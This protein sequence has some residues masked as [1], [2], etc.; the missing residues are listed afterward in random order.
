LRTVP[1]SGKIGLIHFEKGVI[2]VKNRLSKSVCRV[3]CVVL[4]IFS[5]GTQAVYASD[6]AGGGAYLDSMMEFIQDHYYGEVTEDKLV[7]NAVKGMLNSLDDYTTYY[8]NVEKEVFMDSI[9]GVFGGIGV[10]MDISGEYI[11]VL[12]VLPGS[13]AEKA[14]VLQGDKIVE[15]GGTDLVKSNTEKA[16]SV[17]KGEPG[18]TIQLG[19]LRSGSDER[20]YINVV[21]EI[22]KIN[23]VT[24]ENRNGI[25]YI[26][27]NMFNE[28]TDEYIKKALDEFDGRK[29]S[30][31]VLDLRDN[32]GGEVS[33]AV[34]LAELLVPEGLITKL[35]Y[36]SEKYVDIEYYSKLKQ[37]KYKL[38]VLVNGLSASASEIVSGA[39]QDTN[40][41]IL[42]GT[43]T[44]GKAKFQSIMPI[45]SKE[46][47]DKYKEKYNISTVNG[48]ELYDHNIF[49]SGGDISGYAKITLGV[50]YTPN[51]RM[52]DGVGLEPDI[53]VEDP[54]PIA[55]I[56]VNDIQRMT[57]SVELRLNNQG[58]DVYNAK[59]ILR[60]MGY[61]VNTVDNNFD[62]GFEVTLKKFQKDN[63][64]KEN[65]VLDIKTQISLNAHLLE[66]VLQYD[67]QYAAAVNY[68][69]G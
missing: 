33:Q 62:E 50:Y 52:I 11:I 3:F 32:P 65:G 5:L 57:K 14:G 6:D 47:Y 24:H 37:Q 13:P 17:I 30:N 23:P 41:G 29:I 51:G 18:T 59:K 2:S 35:D 25:G 8:N 26:K 67:K 22:I 42:I 10:T 7:D 20:I 63:R 9:T 12:N 68:L 66:L 38:V 31:I 4:L 40:A 1:T 39:I 28:N 19:I 36:K 58:S 64:L 44:Y 27:L 56:Y 55:S 16:S 69:K 60:T 49:P 34:A 48:Y 53:I 46:A 61:E 21:R 15:A 43:K 54:E 45:L